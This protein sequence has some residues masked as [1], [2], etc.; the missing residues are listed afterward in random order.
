ML[1]DHYGIMVFLLFSAGA[2]A[3]LFDAA[4][5][6]TIPVAWWRIALLVGPIVLVAIGDLVATEARSRAWRRSGLWLTALA[7][8][9]HL[10]IDLACVSSA[11]LIAQSPMLSAGCVLA[12]IS[13]AVVLRFAVRSL[14]ADELL[15]YPRLLG[16]MQA[17]PRN[18]GLRLER[19]AWLWGGTSIALTIVSSAFVVAAAIALARRPDQWWTLVRSGLFFALCAAVAVHMGWKRR[20]QLLQSVER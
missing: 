18:V 1:T 20:S 5:G 12:M 17:R 9:V 2:H 15:R 13:M 3:N 19:E 16:A 7:A 10:V 4:F 8:G 11:Q 14:V 6:R